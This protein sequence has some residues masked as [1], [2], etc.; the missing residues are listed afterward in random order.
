MVRGQRH[1]PAALPPGKT[2]YP[3][4]RRLGGPQGRSGRVPKTLTPPGFDPRTVQPVASRYTDWAIPAHICAA[5]INVS[6][7]FFFLP[8][9][10]IWMIR[11]SPRINRDYFP[12]QN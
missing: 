8:K 4:Y 12:A 9:D 1:A 11:T 2:L 7:L 10:C 6:S 5:Y 3:L